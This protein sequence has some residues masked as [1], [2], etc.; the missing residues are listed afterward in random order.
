[1]IK[2]DV[3]GKAHRIFTEWDD[4]TFGDVMEFG[5]VRIPDLF[6]ELLQHNGKEKFNKITDDYF[7]NEIVP[8]YRH[9]ICSFST[10]P[11]EIVSKL[12]IEVLTALIESVFHLLSEMFNLAFDYEQRNRNIITLHGICKPLMSVEGIPG[13]GYPV[14]VYCDGADLISE[15]KDGNT[16]SLL[17]LPA[18]MNQKS[19]VWALRS[20][21]YFKN[22][23][24]TLALD[25]F[26]NIWNLLMRYISGSQRRSRSVTASR[27]KVVRTGLCT[28]LRK[29]GLVVWLN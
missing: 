23:P 25:F 28:N 16:K 1:M 21:R 15:A 6:L 18:V 17:Y 13:V 26:F 12:S 8:Y 9:V 27:S 19:D 5:T 14:S 4:M 10:I 29:R 22:K 7:E 11:K 2:I 3:N 20:L 24:F